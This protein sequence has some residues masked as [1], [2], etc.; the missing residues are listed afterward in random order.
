[1]ANDTYITVC[2]NLAND[3]ELRYTTQNNTPVVSFVVMSTPRTY[4]RN[5]QEWQEGEPLSMRCS[6]WRQMAENVNSSLKKG[7]RVV[8]F[9]RLTQHS[10]ED[11][12]GNRRSRVEMTVEDV[13]AS[14]RTASAQITKTNQGFSNYHDSN[15]PT[16]SFNDGYNAANS[17]SNPFTEI[18]DPTGSTNSVNN[19][20]DNQ[21]SFTDPFSVT[22]TP[23]IPTSP[24]DPMADPFTQTPPPLTMAAGDVVQNEINTNP[25]PANTPKSMPEPIDNPPTPAVNSNSLPNPFE[26]D[27][28]MTNPGNPI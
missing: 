24:V 11:Q 16:E 13:G 4:N 20:F 14:L 15:T 18:G 8:V 17:S 6:A 2:G 25:L 27:P 21:P 5:T 23:P 7:S 28:P 12:Q 3:P 10:Y 26:T 9:G 22:A 19:G 1:M